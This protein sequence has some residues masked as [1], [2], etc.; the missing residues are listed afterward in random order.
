MHFNNWR[1]RIHFIRVLQVFQLSR[2][3]INR[4]H[5]MFVTLRGVII[6]ANAFEGKQVMIAKLGRHKQIASLEHTHGSRHWARVK[7]FHMNIVHFIRDIRQCH[8]VDIA[9]LTLHQ[10]EKQILLF[11]R[12]RRHNQHA[13]RIVTHTTRNQRLNRLRLC[14]VILINDFILGANQHSAWTIVTAWNRNQHVCT[15]IDFFSALSRHMIETQIE[16][17]KSEQF[18]LHRIGVGI[19]VEFTL[20]VQ[21]V[22]FEARKHWIIEADIHAAHG[23]NDGVGFMRF[24][25]R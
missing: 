17:I 2:R 4:I 3:K 24:E 7:I 16:F 23:E 13:T 12:R 19:L 15:W 1:E 8:F 14:I 18:M 21:I 5:A 25:R 20:H 11:M 9:Q 6:I 22:D 10:K